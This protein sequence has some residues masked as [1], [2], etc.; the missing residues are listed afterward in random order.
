MIKRKGKVSNF[1]CTFCGQK[2]MPVVRQ[3][4]KE[5]EDGHLKKLYCV[6]CKQER[7]MVEVKEGGRHTYETF[8]NEFGHGNF[9]KEGNRVLSWKNFTYIPV[10]SFER[11]A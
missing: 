10:H 6:Y 4:G 2:G 9:D 11:G 8:I 1:Y 7:N 3:K 5:R